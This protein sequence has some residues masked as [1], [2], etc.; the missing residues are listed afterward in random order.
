MESDKENMDNLLP[1]DEGRKRKKTR[2]LIAIA[3][4]VVIFIIIVIIRKNGEDKDQEDQKK[5]DKI[6]EPD[7]KFTSIE[8]VTL[9]E[10]I[11]YESH[12]IYSKTGH[13]LLIYKMENDINTTYIGVLNEDGSNLKKLWGGEWK[14]IMELKLME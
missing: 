7:Y 11:I 1:E 10:G 6:A 5:D 8:T 13:L 4:I 12:A 2:L 3:S 14:T 9:P